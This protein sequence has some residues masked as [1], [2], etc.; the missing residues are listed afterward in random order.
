MN[1]QDVSLNNL[2]NKIICRIMDIENT[3][4]FI[5]NNN[6]TTQENIM[7]DI[8]K[9]KGYTVKKI[10]KN[11]YNENLIFCGRAIISDLSISDGAKIINLIEDG[12]YSSVILQL[13]YWGVDISI[14]SGQLIDMN[15]YNFSIEDEVIHIQDTLK[16]FGINFLRNK[17]YERKK[18]ISIKDLSNKIDDTR[19]LRIDKRTIITPAAREM[20]KRKRIRIV[21]K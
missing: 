1:K 18:L 17:I 12:F 9:E 10:E 11:S 16:A 8:F 19:L 20:I 13:L 14:S 2:I 4:I 6:F 7:M 21:R 3:V 15:V 5:G